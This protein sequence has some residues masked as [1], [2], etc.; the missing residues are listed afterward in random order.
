M[1]GRVSVIV[2]MLA[3]TWSATA[4]AG[5]P[6][7]S[8]DAGV[9]EPGKFELEY[10]G[11]YTYDKETVSGVSTKTTSHDGELSV[12]AGIYKNLDLSLAVPY[13]FRE[14]TEENGLLT[15]NAKGFGDMALEVKYAFLEAGGV[16]FAIKP[17]LVIPTGNSGEGRSE[18]GWQP[19]V[20]LIA[21]REFDDGNYA[22]HVNGGYSY[23]RYSKDEDRDANRENL[24]FG[25]VAAE[26]KVVQKLSAGAEIGISTTQDRSTSEVSCFALLGASYEVNDFM[27]LNAGV[28]FGLTRP[29]SD[30]TALYGVT[31]KF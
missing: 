13:T 25:T 5:V 29:E 31:F 15:G 6:F 3:V 30:L 24:W 18:G 2:A 10:A 27:D 16:N 4:F 28:R 1:K 12:T 7:E 11:S 14:H 17:T 19:G 9:V 26:A 8:D 22:V 20:V 23:H 21:T